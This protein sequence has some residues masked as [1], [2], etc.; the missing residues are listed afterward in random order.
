M[1]GAFIQLTRIATRKWL[2]QGAHE[3]DDD[4]WGWGDLREEA[5]QDGEEVG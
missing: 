3:R 5:D 2:L 4:E 1:L